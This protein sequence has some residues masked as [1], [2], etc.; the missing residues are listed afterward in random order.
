M[1]LCIVGAPCDT[2]AHVTET[3]SLFAFEGLSIL[4]L[5]ELIFAIGA[6]DAAV[7]RSECRDTDE[8][9]II[10]RSFGGNVVLGVITRRVEFVG[11]LIRN[12]DWHVHAE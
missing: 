2:K 7:S 12:D 9:I 1:T 3:C 11:L 5:E 4:Q 6:V 8:H 10:C